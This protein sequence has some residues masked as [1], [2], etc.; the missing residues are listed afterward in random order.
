[1]SMTKRKFLVSFIG[2]TILLVPF[3]LIKK[4]IMKADSIPNTL[5]IKKNFAINDPINISVIGDSWAY[6]A[7]DRGLCKALDSLLAKSNITAHTRNCG[8]LGAKSRDIYCYLLSQEPPHPI[9][10]LIESQ[11]NYAILFC[12][13]NDQNAQCGADFYS[14]HTFNI[15]TS[16]VEANVTPIY[17]ELPKWNIK[18]QYQ[19]YR[20]WRYFSYKILC[21]ITSH[22]FDETAT[23]KM[24]RDAFYSKLAQ[25]SIKANVIFIKWETIKANNIWADDLHLNK[26][27]YHKLAEII[28][29]SIQNH[30][31]SVK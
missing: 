1:M 10:N 19:K 14:Y 31:I 24:Y 6:Y 18:K 9:H 29:D 30:T 2:I 12:G 15:L 17:I 7:D 25:S 26:I 20:W 28:A 5:T 11:T 3:I 21:G 27:G 13:I 8:V 23:T 22:Q 16:L 4:R